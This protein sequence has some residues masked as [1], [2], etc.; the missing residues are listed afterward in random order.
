[1]AAL[2]LACFACTTNEASCP[3]DEPASCPSPVPSYAN[4][5]A[6][7][8]QRYCVGPCH[9]PGG[10]GSTAI[11]TWSDIEGRVT[12]VHEQIYQCLMPMPGN[13]KPTE[14]ERVTLLTWFVCGAPNN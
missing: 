4:D 8:I 1:M 2:W 10:P 7:L 9:Y 5:I 12:T 14:E 11:A 3:A 13:P 6:P